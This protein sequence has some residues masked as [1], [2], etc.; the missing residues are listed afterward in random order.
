VIAR[1]RDHGGREHARLGVLGRR[2]AGGRH[3]REREKKHHDRFPDH[4]S[5]RLT[6]LP[7]APRLGERSLYTI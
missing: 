6:R 7:G 5:A 3:E 1:A 4:R 2:G